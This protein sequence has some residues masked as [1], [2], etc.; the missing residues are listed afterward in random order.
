LPTYTTSSSNNYST[1]RDAVITRALRIIGAIGQGETPATAAVTEA[2]EAL[3]DL[4][5]AWEADGMTLWCNKEYTI[6]P[7]AS[8]AAYNIGIGQTTNAVA[9]LRVVQ[10]WAKYTSTGA[11]TPI[12][13]IT[14]QEYQ[15][16]SNKTTTGSPSQVWYN[17]PGSAVYTGDNNPFGTATFFVTPDSNFASG[18]TIRLWGTRPFEDFDASTDVPDFPQ[19]WYNALKWGLADQLSYEYGVGLAERA[20]ITKKA[21]QHKMEALSYGTEEG[22]L[23]IQPMPHWQPE[24][25]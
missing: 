16:L 15:M 13:V 25:W 22:S 2:A 1:S 10:A 24:S 23:K 9:P 18:F 7:V 14:R 8:T 17:P 12:L 19:Y 20:M 21:M 11:D 6:T 5:K 3:N 4:C